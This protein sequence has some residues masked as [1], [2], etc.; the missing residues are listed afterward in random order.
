M[1]DLFVGVWMMLDTLWDWS[2]SLN[3]FHFIAFTACYAVGRRH[4]KETPHVQPK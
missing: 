2:A 3:T 4:G 1:N